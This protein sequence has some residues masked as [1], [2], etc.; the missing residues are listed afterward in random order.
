M[1]VQF[2]LYVKNQNKSTDFYS[3][4]LDKE[5]VLFVKGMTE[6]IL[7][8]KTKLGL[9]PNK[10]IAKLFSKQIKH[11]DSGTMI[12]RCEL[13]LYVSDVDLHYQKAIA[14][15]ARPINSPKL[16][17]WG[18]YV[19]YVMDTDGHIIAFYNDKIN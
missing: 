5:P 7:N 9:M 19:G 16:R 1:Q 15:G 6:F 13:Y 14:L 11:P 2:I 3:K 18:D 4:L 12:P 10:G 8:D 17:D